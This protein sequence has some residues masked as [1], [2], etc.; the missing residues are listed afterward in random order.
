VNCNIN[1]NISKILLELKK[2]LKENYKV[3]DE[4]LKIDYQY[5]KIKVNLEMLENVIDELKMKK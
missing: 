1:N 2:V 4:L 5:C 3:I